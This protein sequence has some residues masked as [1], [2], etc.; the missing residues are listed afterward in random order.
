MIEI[1]RETTEKYSHSAMSRSRRVLWSRLSAG[2]MGEDHRRQDYCSWMQCLDKLSWITE[3][4][5][6]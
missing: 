6:V 3:P 1:S 4:D 2:L 5:E